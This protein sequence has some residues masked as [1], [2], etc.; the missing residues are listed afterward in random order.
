MLENVEEFRDW[1]PLIETADG[2]LIPCPLRKGFT[3]K[4]WVRE[5]KK[6]GYAVEHREL[7]ACDYGA[8][9]IRKRLFLIARCD[10]API[11]WPMPSHAKGGMRP[12]AGCCR[13][14]PRRSASTGRCR[15]RRSSTGRSR[16]PRRRCG[17]SRAGSALCARRE[18]A[19]HRGLAHG[20][21]RSG[22]AR[23]VMAEEP[24]GPCMPA[25]A[26]SPRRS[27]HRADHA[28]RR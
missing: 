20:T 6:L 3:F 14:A 25:A 8:P 16:W 23:D 22:R 18:E 5:L 11:V 7:R 21:H 2:K 24:I 13:G 1:G 19:V 9:T 12:P 27:V 10:G 28:C 26:T 15:A 4:R 17:G